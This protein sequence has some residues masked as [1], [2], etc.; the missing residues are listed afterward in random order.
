MKEIYICYCSEKQSFAQRVCWY[1]EKRGHECWMAP[2]DVRSGCLLAS[3][4]RQSIEECGVF[5]LLASEESI[6]SPRVLNELAIAFERG[7]KILPLFLEPVV[8]PEDYLIFLQDYP[9]IEGWDDLNAAMD[10]VL[11]IAFG[12]VPPKEEEIPKKSSVQSGKSS[13]DSVRVIPPAR[14]SYTSKACMVTYEDLQRIGMDA[15]SIAERLMENDHLLYEDIDKEEEGTADGWA[16]YLDNYPETFRYLVN[17]GNEIVG[18]W[19]FLALSEEDHLERMRKGSLSESEF[20]VSNTEFIGFPGDYY[21]YILNLSVNRGYNT[22]PN[23]RLL[24]ESLTDQLLAYAEEGIFFRSWFVNLF[25]KD[26]EAMFKRTGFRFLYKKEGQEEQPKEKSSEPIHNAL[27]FLSKTE[28]Q[29]EQ[30]TEEST[31]PKHG[32]VYELTADRIHLF[33]QGRSKDRLIELYQEHFASQ[34]EEE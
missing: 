22:I 33:A 21:A 24:F 29:E 3:E 28:G 9:W 14:N 18:Y 16:Q 27:K 25:R 15:L 5:L 1:L 8:V 34:E 6:H 26:H 32:N 12:E 4:I 20:D 2:R 17:E 30:S 31:V 23:Y 19:A 7:K 10:R 11:E 13:S